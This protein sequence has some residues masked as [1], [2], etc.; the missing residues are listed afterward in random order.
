MGAVRALAIVLLLGCVAGCRRHPEPK[1][2]ASSHL[3][4]A[5]GPLT[6]DD[7]DALNAKLGDV[8]AVPVLSMQVQA[9]GEDTNWQTRAIGTSEAYFRLRGWSMARGETFTAADVA[10]GA[11]VAVLGETVAKQLFADHAAVGA[12]IR[13][14]KQPFTIVGVATSLGG[15]NDVVVVPFTTYRA[16]LAPTTSG[17]LGGIVLFSSPDVTAAMKSVASF[18]RARHGA[19][20]EVEVLRYEE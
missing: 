4:F 1:R 5:R 11:R 9:L 6:W 2:A 20:G 7:F 19:D 18:L 14:G 16:K 12:T 15:S 13:L 3:A 17:D 10:N 8:E